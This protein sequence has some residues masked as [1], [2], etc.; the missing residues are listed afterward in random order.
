MMWLNSTLKTDQ[1]IVMIKFYKVSH[2]LIFYVFVPLLYPSTL[3][4]YVCQFLMRKK[5]T[6]TKNVLGAQAHTK[7]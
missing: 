6:K 4:V 7:N 1:T 5:K 3:T 2:A